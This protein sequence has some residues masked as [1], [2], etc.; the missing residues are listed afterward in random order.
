MKLF[1]TK[2]NQTE[3]QFV[4][5]AQ[6]RRSPSLRSALWEALQDAKTVLRCF[7]GSYTLSR[8]FRRG[9]SFV[10]RHLV[11]LQHRD[12]T[13]AGG[14]W[15][16][17]LWSLQKRY[18]CALLSLRSSATAALFHVPCHSRSIQGE[19]KETAT[20][21][22]SKPLNVFSQNNLGCITGQYG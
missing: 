9:A 11:R 10:V 19:C 16:E 15:W 22:E 18:S 2:S 1:S 3:I 21:L 17:W 5:S 14:K 13:A 4:S 20:Q 8:V 7:I 12:V 6:G